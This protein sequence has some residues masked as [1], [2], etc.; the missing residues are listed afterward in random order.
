M[1]ID[2][3]T[4]ESIKLIINAFYKKVRTNEELAP[5][6]E[7]AIGKTDAEW[8]P[9]LEVMYAFWSSLMLGSGRYQ[10]N[11]MRKHMELPPFNA[12]L[13]DTWLALFAETAREIHPEPIADLY[14]TRS[15]RIAESLKLGL[16]Y[17][18]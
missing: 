12:G 11:P 2:T 17:K 4:E 9:H 10:G 3:I 16:Y 1:T 8:Q 6:F 14:I 7:A 13:F 18:P 15:K 5:I